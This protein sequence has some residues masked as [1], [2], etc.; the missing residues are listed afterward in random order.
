MKEFAVS[1]NIY[2]GEGALERLAA[3]PYRK[4]LIFTDP[5]VAKSGLIRQVTDRLERAGIRYE[6]DTDVVPDP[7]VEKVASGIAVLLKSRPD[8][9]VAV[10]GGSAIDLAKAVL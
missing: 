8:C 1:T 9:I 5:F 3:L 7:P 2:F 6:V 4:V 10:V